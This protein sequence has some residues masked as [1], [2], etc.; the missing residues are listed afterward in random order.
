MTLNKAQIR[1]NRSLLIGLFLIG[2]S[3]LGVIATEIYAPYNLYFER[4]IILLGINIIIVVALNLSNGFTGVFSL[5]HV[6]FMAIG[7]YV[8][9]I[10]T[11][12]LGTKAT[13]LPDLPGWLSQIQLSF[14]PALLIAGL[15]AAGIAFLIGIPLMRLSGHYVS[16]ATLGFLVI[17]HVIL[18]NWT[19]FT[20]GARTFS[21]VPQYTNIWWVY[22]WIVITVYLVWRVIHTNYGRAMIAVREDVIAAQSTGINILNARNRAFVLSAFLTAVGG[23]LMAHYLTSFSPATFYFTATFNYII[24]LVVGGMGSISGSIIGATLVTILSE[25]LRNAE[26]GVQIGSINIP[27]VYGLSQ[28]ILSISFIL[29]VIFRRSGIM[30]DHELDFSWLVRRRSH[31]TQT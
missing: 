29:I 14:V 19:Q 9:A 23:G 22:I 3:L 27:A 18:I 28:I 4:V 31:P 5:G 21:G 16:V 7:A 20:R 2:I 15:I 10:L 25:I 12:P 8:S 1:I 6:G 11:L 13:N 17:V 24:M 30:G 26:L